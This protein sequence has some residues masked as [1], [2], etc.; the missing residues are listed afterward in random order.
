MRT[1]VTRKTGTICV[2]AALL[3]T[4]CLGSLDRAA[5][6]A[7]DR[8]VIARLTLHLVAVTSQSVDVSGVPEGRSPSAFLPRLLF[9]PVAGHPGVYRWEFGAVAAG[10]RSNVCYFNMPNPCLGVQFFGPDGFEA[11]LDL[12]HSA[13]PRYAAA[14][15]ATEV[16]I[17]DGYDSARPNEAPFWSGIQFRR[18]SNDRVWPDPR[19]DNRMPAAGDGGK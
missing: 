13:I 4:G 2:C 16:Q 11:A 19:Y 18:H 5:R 9:T 10:L 6:H 14:I 3:L 15:S 1:A 12:D 7:H 17:D 8:P